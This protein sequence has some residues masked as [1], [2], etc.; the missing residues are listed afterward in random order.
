MA[1]CWTGVG[2]CGVEIVL[3]YPDSSM[4]K[5]VADGMVSVGVVKL[6]AVAM[7]DQC[8]LLDLNIKT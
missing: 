7:I 3:W 6:L 5:F 8:T 1:S 4:R 2:A